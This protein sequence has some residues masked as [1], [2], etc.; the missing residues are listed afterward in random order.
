MCESAVALEQKERQKLRVPLAAQF[1]CSQDNKD[2][3][4]SS[5]AGV[6]CCGEFHLG[7]FL[8]VSDAKVSTEESNGVCETISA[9]RNNKTIHQL[10]FVYIV[11]G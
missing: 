6:L 7:Q 9:K 2:P 3:R 4:Y 1:Y 10:M 8:L 5:E 11:Y